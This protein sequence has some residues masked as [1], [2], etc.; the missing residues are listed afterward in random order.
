MTSTAT[1]NKSTTTTMSAIKL[2]TP[3]NTTFSRCFHNH[4]AKQSPTMDSSLTI[5]L[6]SEHH[7][8]LPHHLTL[9]NPNLAHLTPNNGFT[10]SQQ[11]SLQIRLRCL[12]LSPRCS[13]MR[14]LRCHFTNPQRRPSHHLKK[15]QPTLPCRSRLQFITSL[16]PPN[17][18]HQVMTL[19]TLAS[20]LAIQIQMMASPSLT[21]RR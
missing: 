6:A 12:A 15:D 10:Q 14:L 21:S 7:Y 20:P 2:K 3:P 16:F 1:T 8:F 18:Y 4:K 9:L 11:G 5:P 17:Q 19:L 13:P